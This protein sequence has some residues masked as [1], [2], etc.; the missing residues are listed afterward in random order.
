MSGI[1][2]SLD[3]DCGHL[4]LLA[5]MPYSYLYIDNKLKS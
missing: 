3:A 5:E 1:N 4:D 2:V